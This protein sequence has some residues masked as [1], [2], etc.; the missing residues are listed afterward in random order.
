MQMLLD[1]H[2]F[3]YQATVPWPTSNDSQVDWV[4]GIQV[5]ESWLTDH[6][7]PRL[8]HWAWTDSQQVYYVGVA[9]KWDQDRLLFVIAWA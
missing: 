1:Q 3:Q 9:F 8:K 6:V 2:I 5:V 4:H 7:G